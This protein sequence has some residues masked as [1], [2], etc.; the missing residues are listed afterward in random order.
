MA[1]MRMAD[2]PGA[3]NEYL[4]RQ[5]AQSENFY[6]LPVQVKDLMPCDNA[7][8][9]LTQL[10]HMPAAEWSEKATVKNQQYI[11]SAGKAGK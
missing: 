10:R 6:F 8:I 5:S 7:L 4:G 9:F 3:V 1:V 11:L 2:Y